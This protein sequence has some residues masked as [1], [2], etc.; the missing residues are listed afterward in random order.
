MGKSAGRDQRPVGND[1]VVDQPPAEE[2][3]P[4]QDHFD[5]TCT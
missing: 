3:G 4:C 2:L 1:D 5:R